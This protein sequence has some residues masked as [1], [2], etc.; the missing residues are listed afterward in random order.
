[1]RSPLKDC[2]MCSA[3]YT[4]YAHI[5]YDNMN[6]MHTAHVIRYNVTRLSAFGLSTQNEPKLPKSIDIGKIYLSSLLIPAFT[7]EELDQLV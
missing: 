6:R 3:K 1:M 2:N 7:Q 5:L 4:V